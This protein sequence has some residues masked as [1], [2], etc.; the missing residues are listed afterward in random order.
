MKKLIISTMLVGTLFADSYQDWLN[1]QSQ[2][3]NSYKKSMDEEFS[4]MLKKDWEAFKALTTPPA[5][6]KPKPTKMPK[7]K[8]TVVIPKKELKSSPIVKEKKIF[9]KPITKLKVKVSVPKVDS[10]Y[11]KAKF[12]FYSI[13]IVVKYDKKTKF[14]LNK[15]D[16][17][18]ISKFWDSMSATNYKLILTQVKQKEKE[19]NLN[20][21]AKYKF[22]YKLADSIF[23]D[24]NI[25][26]LFSWF[27]L[28]KL[29]YDIKVGY[30]DNRIYLLSTVANNMYQ[31]AFFKLNSKKYYIIEPK[32][33][34][35]RVGSIYTY[36]GSYPK[37]NKK[38]SFDI[39]K[40]MKLYNDIASRNLQFR[41]GGK[42]H[43]VEAKYSR[44]LIKFYK[45][46]PQVDYKV[47]FDT[48][49]STILS[50]SMLNSLAKLIKGKSEVEAVN[51][52][53]RF[54]QTAFKYKTDQKQFDY[55]KVMFPEETVFYPYSDC[56]DRSI[57]FSYL[58]RN[59]LGL[60]VVG[61]KYSDHLA[62]AVQFSSKVSGDGFIYK[63]KKYTIADPTYINANYG[64]TMPQYKRA[65][66]KIV[67][68]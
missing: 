46:F 32:G 50:N 61:V 9:T 43:K 22:V 66:F 14:T 40:E 19:L 47:Y 26:N 24:K 56:E 36:A 65:K 6:K 59:L 30:N 3:Y 11:K 2:S 54:T 41:Y 68:I 21:W 17:N 7:V 48:K 4:N 8:K 29:N 62:T 31:V 10:R 28:T 53:L 37:A 16:K 35:Q 58:V 15:I 44:D 52:L 64:M 60:K 67:S 18:I 1:A 27:I 63:G 13:P 45:S 12:D 49:N 23:H 33:R 25:D 20:D 51:I 38:L 5:L 42:L 39:Y 34:I 57:M 55:E